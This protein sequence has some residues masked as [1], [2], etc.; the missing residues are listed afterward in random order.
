MSDLEKRADASET[1]I[2]DVALQIQRSDETLEQ[3]LLMAKSVVKEYQ[4]LKRRLE[5]TENQLH[6]ANVRIIGLSDNMK[7]EDLIGFFRRLIPKVLNINVQEDPLYIERTYRISTR[8]GT[9]QESWQTIILR[10]L[11][12]CDRDQI[13]QA[14]RK[15]KDIVYEDNKI[16]F[17]PEL[18]L[19][20]QSKRMALNVIKKDLLV[21]LDGSGELVMSYRAFYL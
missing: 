8:N 10:L 11:S 2:A 4:A 21:G 12:V 1:K 15:M 14:A 13:I 7:C 18:S 17:F 16:F 20:S 3:S 6:E 19:L 9:N 5:V